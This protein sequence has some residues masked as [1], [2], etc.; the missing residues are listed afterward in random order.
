MVTLET[1]RLRLRPF[2]I[3]DL[4]AHSAMF[5]NPEVTRFVVAGGQPMSRFA[6]WQALCANVG[7]WHFRGFGQFAVEEKATGTLVGRV[8][9]WQPEGWPDF[10][11]GWALRRESWGRG[12]ATE[13]AERC[14]AFAF[15]ELQRP[16]LVSLIDPDNLPSIRVAERLGERIE[17]EFAL[18]S[19][20]NRPVRQYGLHKSDWT[21]RS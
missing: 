4:D 17:G 1:E 21:P 14:V 7:H 16:H 19:Q 18:P 5:A 15:T 10:E 3:D 13:A 8:G 6:S 2:T 12:Y 11:I 9:P 20:P